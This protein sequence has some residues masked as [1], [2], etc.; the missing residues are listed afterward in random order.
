MEENFL[1]Q[2]LRQPLDPLLVNREGLLSDVVVG[3]RQVHCHHEIIKK[4]RKSFSSWRSKKQNCHL[5]LPEF[6]LF[7]RLIKGA[8]WEAVMKGKGV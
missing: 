2:M 6:G 4:K 5:G 7:R 3:G 8:F 1:T